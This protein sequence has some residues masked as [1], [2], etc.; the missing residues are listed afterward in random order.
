MSF[1]ELLHPYYKNLDLDLILSGILFHDIGKVKG[2]HY[3]T[4]G[5]YTDAGSL[6]VIFPWG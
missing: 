6:L 1:A 2:F 5:E 3:T 4:K